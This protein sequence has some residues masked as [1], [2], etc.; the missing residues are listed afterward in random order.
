MGRRNHDRGACGGFPVCEF[1]EGLAKVSRS[2]YNSQIVN[3]CTKDGGKHCPY[4]IARKLGEYYEMKKI[5]TGA[6]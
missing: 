2:H 5:K 1:L 3:Y 4:T 6:V